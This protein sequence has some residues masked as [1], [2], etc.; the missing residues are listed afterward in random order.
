MTVTDLVTEFF[1][2]LLS[3]TVS[4]TSNVPALL[5][6]CEAVSPDEPKLQL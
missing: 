6:V 4:V 3:V 1:A 5:N 2:P